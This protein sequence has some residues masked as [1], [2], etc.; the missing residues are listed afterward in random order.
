MV[1]LNGS[2][3]FIFSADVKDQGLSSKVNLVLSQDDYDFLR[4]LRVSFPIIFA[5]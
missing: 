2:Q 1:V 4:I 3:V 5:R